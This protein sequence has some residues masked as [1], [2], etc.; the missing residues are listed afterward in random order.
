[1]KGRWPDF[2]DSFLLSYSQIFFSKDRRV[3]AL[4][5]A[6]TAIHPNLLFGGGAAVLLCHLF[7]RLLNLSNEAIRMGMYGYNG[8]LV[9]LAFAF[10]F[11]PDLALLIVFLPALF[12]VVLITAALRTPL[13]YYFNLPVLTLPFLIVFFP[14]LSASKNIQGIIPNLKEVAP[15]VFE[16][17]FFEMATSYLKSLGAILF[18]PDTVSG[19][20]LFIALLFFSRIATL[21]SFMGF[22][23]AVALIRWVFNF[24]MEHL[25]LSVGFNFILTSIA[26]GGIW[27]VPQKSSFLLA[28][29]AVL[30][31]AILWASSA[32]LLSSLGLPVLI[33]PFNLT[34]LTF[35]YAMSQRTL[36][37]HPKSVDFESDTPESKLSHY[38]TRIMRF[39]SHF[40]HPISLPFLGI[41]TCTQGPA[42]PPTHQAF[43]EHAY[44]FEVKDSSG[45]SFK[46]GGQEISDYFCYKLPILACADGQIVKVINHLPDNPIGEPNLKENWGN[47]TMIQHSP[48]RFSMVCHLA[49]G[50][51]RFKEGDFVRKGN[52]IGLCGNSG[53]S[54]VPHLHFHLQATSRIGSP[55]I[56][57]EFH[58]VV[59]EGPSSLLVSTYAPQEGERVRSINRNQVVADYFA[60]PIGQKISFICR[61]EDKEWY[62]EVET[63]IDLYGHLCLSSLTRKTRLLFENKNSLFVI[64]DF[65]GSLDS[66]LSILY[67]S[68]PRVPYESTENLVYHDTLPLR[69][70]LPKIG[71]VLSD[72][73]AP[74]F[75]RKGLKIEYQCKLSGEDF[76][77]SGHSSGENL[78]SYSSIETK[79]IFREGLG[80]VESHLDRK[81]KKIEVIRLQNRERVI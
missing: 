4:M 39:G 33:L 73:T 66:G 74:F 28:G 52:I 3:G 32:E 64:Y 11:K 29:S 24:P 26:M 37:A 9:G 55:T 27:F 54:S 79:A 60:F 2:L 42:T 47:L 68:A 70:L 53:R 46:N 31:C 45:K 48:S 43:W 38:Q 59:L 14:V 41:W 71:R 22:A 77:V 16:F 57:S 67:A 63:S 58:E 7:A 21:L 25:Y 17:P 50:P 34:L 44:D 78:S 13:G 35:L 6:A 1:M 36:D 10:F 51:S 40:Q 5:F 81:E 19:A 12:S 69:H 23:M 76:I 80:W 56:H 72:L 8:L 20:I 15:S 65:E 75:N 61:S 30:L 49:A 18:M 62:E